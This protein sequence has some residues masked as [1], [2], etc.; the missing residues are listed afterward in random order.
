MV[1][2]VAWVR[3]R[4]CGGVWRRG[5]GKEGLSLESDGGF[6]SAEET[7]AEA[8]KAEVDFILRRRFARAGHGHRGC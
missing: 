8:A 1:D 4:G 7:L 6:A 2:C 5:L 3:G